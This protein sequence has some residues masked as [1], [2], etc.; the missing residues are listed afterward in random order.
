MLLG[1]DNNLKLLKECD[2]NSTEKTAT[3]INQAMFIVIAIFFLLCF[4]ISEAHMQIVTFKLKKNVRNVAN[5]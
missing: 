4:R 2:D 3:D 1:L 5:N